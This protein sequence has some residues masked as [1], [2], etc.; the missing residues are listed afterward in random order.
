MSNDEQVAKELVETLKDGEK[1]FSSAADK[2]RDGDRPE[3]AV[4]LQRLSEQRAGFHGE[5]VA[6]VPSQSLAAGPI[7]YLP[8][9]PPAWLAEFSIVPLALLVFAWSGAARFNG[10]L[11]RL[12][13]RRSSGSESRG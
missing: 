1:G 5:I 4:T 9:E 13:T 3:W 10:L 6:E 7:Y 11:V 2:L 8:A 12:F